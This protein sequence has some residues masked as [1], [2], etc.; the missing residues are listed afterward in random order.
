MRKIPMRSCVVTKEKLPK[1]E[2]FRI[3]RT[4]EQKI[5]IDLKG[6]ENGR[7]AYLKKELEVIEKAFKSKVLEKHLGIQIPIEIYEKLKELI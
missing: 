4:P 3:V 2:L 6:K 5:I 7:G 1:Y